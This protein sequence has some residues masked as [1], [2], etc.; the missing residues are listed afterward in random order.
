MAEVER[1]EE[2]VRQALRDVMRHAVSGHAVDELGRLNQHNSAFNTFCNNPDHALH[3]LAEA[4][5][6]PV[7]AAIAD[8][9]LDKA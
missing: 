8:R 1:F 2:K 9:L 5:L 3:I 7:N 6:R 4:G